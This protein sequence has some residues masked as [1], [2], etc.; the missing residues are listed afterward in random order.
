M[1]LLSTYLTPT[2]AVI[3]NTTDTPAPVQITNT[4]DLL[5][6]MAYYLGKLVKMSESSA[7]V[8]TAQRQRIAVETFLGSAGFVR[9]AENNINA[10]VYQMFG[11]PFQASNTPV[12]TVPDVWKIIDAAR[13]NYG[14][15]IRP[16]LT[17]T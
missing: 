4:D 1:P 7:V 10:P 14:A 16:N 11:N 6:E 2:S 9:L 5:S 17:F 13:Q 3:I 15:S 8:D 12:F